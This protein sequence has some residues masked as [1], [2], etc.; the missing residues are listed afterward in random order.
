MKM[1]KEYPLEKL[2]LAP[3]TIY[4]PKGAEVVSVQDTSLGLMLYAL[5]N[6]A[7]IATDIRTFKICNTSEN[8]YSNDVK[9]IGSIKAELGTCHIV[10]L[11]N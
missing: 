5:I 10:E 8:F 11:L 6:S 1:F 3:Q 2:S 7:E 9:Y 4:L